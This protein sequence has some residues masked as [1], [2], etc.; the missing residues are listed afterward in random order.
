LPADFREFIGFEELA[1]CGTLSLLTGILGTY[2]CSAIPAEP[3]PAQ[4]S[5]GIETLARENHPLEGPERR[6]SRSIAVAHFI[7]VRANTE[8]K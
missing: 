6:A 8:S 7:G 1:V 4:A 3:L 5:G 2:L